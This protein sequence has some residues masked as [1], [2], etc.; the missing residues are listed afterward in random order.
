MKRIAVAQLLTESNGLNP[1]PTTRAHFE[2]FGIAAGAA[3]LEQYGDVGE[4]AGLVTLPDALGEDVEW[5][6]LVRAVAW[7]GGPLADDTLHHF[8]EQIVNPLREHPVDGV[9][10]ALHGAVCAEGE[11]DVTGR[12]LDDVRKIVGPDC[13][14]VATLDLHTNLTR[15]MV[16]AAD[17]LV[18]YHTFPHR[19]QVQ[20]GRRAARA[21]AR[22]LSAPHRIKTA[23]W[24]IP[25]IT[26]NDGRAT[27]TGILADLWQRLV[28]AEQPE[29]VLSVG[30]FMAQPYLDLPQLGWALYQAWLGGAPPLD[31]EAAARECWQTRAYAKRRFLPPREI[32]PAALAVPGRPV[33]V[34]EGCDA[35]NSGA[36]GDSTRLLAELVRNDIPDGGALTFCIDPHAVACCYD[37]GSG[38]S[39]RLAI[40]GRGTRTYCD[41]LDVVARVASLGNVTYVLTGHVGHNLRVDMGRTAVVVCGNAT[42]LLTEH[43]GP[44][45]TPKLYE[46]A[47]L[48]PRDFKIVAAKSPEGFRGDYESFAAGILYCAAPGC[49]TP[50]LNDVPYKNVDRPLHP[51][52][53]FDQIDQATWAGD[54]IDRPAGAL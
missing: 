6:G 36:P 22:L 7:P 30:L 17:V 5:L 41:P 53:T 27:D 52:D 4:L 40:G 15:R 34:S 11:S 31:L 16:A 45:S 12:L 18:G 25:M 3:V 38:A 48:D 14:V 20:T 8:T 26:N 9:L 37:A 28:A 50:H 44:G 33:V 21:L 51:I 43:S 49:A 10:L 39:I 32:I 47:G 54:M 1:V 35:T 46:A 2:P 42:I 29:D 19:D 23:A 13:P 24:K